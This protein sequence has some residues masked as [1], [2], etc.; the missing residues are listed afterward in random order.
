VD[1]G[2]EKIG[3]GT[4][5]I[6]F[7]DPGLTTRIRNTGNTVGTWELWTGL[8]DKLGSERQVFGHALQVVEDSHPR[9]G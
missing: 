7:R 5:K 1:P 2:W 9:P 4:E 3:S 6:R 8:V